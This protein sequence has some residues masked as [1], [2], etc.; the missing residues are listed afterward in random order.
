MLKG[1]SKSTYENIQK[2]I[3]V[4]KEYIVIEDDYQQ[5]RMEWVLGKQTLNVSTITKSINA[6]SS[7][8]FEERLYFFDS[9]LYVE[10]GASFL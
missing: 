10:Q 5:M 1:F 4:M 8:N 9:S 6:L 7:K 3:E 2:Y